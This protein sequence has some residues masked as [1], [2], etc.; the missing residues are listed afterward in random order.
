MIRPVHE[1]TAREATPMRAEAGHSGPLAV[2]AAAFGMGLGIFA[3]YFLVYRTRHFGMP[4][5]FDTSWYVWRAQYV[6]ENGLG[7]LATAVR[8]GHALLASVLGSVS[9]RPQLTMAVV[10]PLALVSTFALAVGAFTSIGL[11]ARRWRWAVAVTVTGTLLGATRLVGEN[12][13]NLLLLA[14]VVAALTALTRWISGGPG[15][16]GSVALLVAAGL[17]HWTF[18]AVIGAMLAGSAVL[19]LPASRR[20][21]AVGVP[22]V[23]TETGALGAAIGSTAALMLAVVIGVL[24]AP[25]STF[26]IREETRRF[27]PKLR[28]DLRRVVWPLT[29]PVAALGAVHLARY[30]PVRSDPTSE[31]RPFALR[32]LTAWTAVAAIGTVYGIATLNLP[33]HRFLTLLVAV[34]G[35]IAV[36]AAVWWLGAVVASRV[37]GRSGSP[38]PTALGAA[39][40]LVAVGVLSIP[41]GLAWYR[42]GPGVWFDR[43]TLRESQT[44]AGYVQTLRPGTPIVF[45]VGPFGDAGLLSVP[46][47][48]R[49]IRAGL[50]VDREADMYLFVGDPD[51]LVAG[52]RTHVSGPVDHATQR[53]WEDV[54]TVLP[55]HPP[56]VV[57][58]ATGQGQFAAAITQG[59]D[60]IAPGVALLQGPPPA[61]AVAEQPVPRPVPR[62]LLGLLWGAVLLSLLGAAGLGWARLIVGRGV[63]PEVRWSMAPAVGAGALILGG[64]VAVKLGV[65]LAGP[66]G[67]ATYVVVTLAG[68]ALAARQRGDRGYS[69]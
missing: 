34:P 69:R 11:G 48:E 1:A 40:T 44:A 7:P 13:A 37:R 62:T 25:F 5:G 63:P 47:K 18:L 21:W 67:V 22:I 53:Y 6:A 56:V 3:L 50:P 32:V 43:A 41:G 51:D 39:A 59:A 17:A 14:L 15:L 46:L 8:P 60:L 42:H 16:P 23:R 38:W 24:R 65:R 55:E 4:V 29:G 61:S 64:L 19:A 54:R 28:E 58:Q 57:L 68:A 26:E 31:P 12:V 2:P 35:A 20:R 45:L 9:G 66:G 52:R 30:R 27:I 33:P 10:L 49:N 36:A